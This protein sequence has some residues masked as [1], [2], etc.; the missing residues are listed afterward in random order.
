MVVPRFRRKSGFTLIELLVAIAIIAILA[1]LLCPAVSKA[2]EKAYNIKCVSNLRQQ[3]IGWTASV[4]SDDGRLWIQSGWGDIVDARRLY[5]GTAQARWW[6]DD[7]GKTNKGSICPA[8]PERRAKDRIPHPYVVGPGVYP[9]AV[10][11]AWVHEFPFVGGW[12]WWMDAP[13]NIN[14]RRAGSYSQNHWLGG[15]HWG[16]AL[17]EPNIV[18]LPEPFRNENQIVD[19]SRTPLFADAIHW[20]FGAGGFW[21]GPRAIDRPASNLA[22]GGFPGP[23]WGMS[24]FTIPRHGSKPRNIST[25]HSMNAKLPGAINVAFYDGHVEQVKLEKLWQLYWHRN[26]QPPNR[27]PGL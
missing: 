1:S 6:R 25:N 18:N 7:W 27:R 10:N 3:A 13:P 24:S 26:Y 8:A 9:G 2:K 4:E 17:N 12:W 23:P 19:A 16:W 20:P 15:Y 5:S 22:S 21:H 14:E 11:A